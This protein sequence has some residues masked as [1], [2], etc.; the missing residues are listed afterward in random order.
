MT[1]QNSIKGMIFGRLTV[2]EKRGVARNRSSMWACLCTCGKEVVV[3]GSSLKNGNT[4]SCGCLRKERLVASITTHGLSGGR[5]FTPRLYRIW[6][7]MKSRCNNKNTPKFKN[8]GGRG[9]ALCEEWNRYENFHT[10][11]VGSGYSD[12]LT[13]DRRDNNE[14]YFPENCRWVTARDQGNNKRTNHRV[15]IGETT[16]TI[17]EWCDGDLKKANAVYGRINRYGWTPEK[18]V[19]TPIRPRRM[20]I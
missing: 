19:L 9:I 12:N 18:A 20:S 13:I 5:H 11:A 6:R 15:A 4:R 16:K 3:I 17:S 8:H 10:W 14:G 7:N 2:I 1:K